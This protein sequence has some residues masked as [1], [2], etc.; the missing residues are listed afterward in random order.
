MQPLIAELSRLYLLEPQMCVE[1]GGGGGAREPREPREPR[2]ALSPGRLEQHLLGLKTVAVDLVSPAATARAFVLDFCA[3]G[4]SRGEQQWRALCVLANALRESLQLPAPAVSI[5]GHGFQLWL[6][7]ATPA[8]LAEIAEFVQRLHVDCLPD[9]SDRDNGLLVTVVDL[10]PARQASGKWAAF[11]HPGMGASF[12]DDPALEMAPPVG[13]QVGFLD[14]LRSIDSAQF[15]TALATLR[16]RQGAPQPVTPL[17]APL[18][19][20][21]PPASSNA[22]PDGL[23]LKDASL[24]DIVA[25]LHAR[26]IEPT[27]RYCLPGS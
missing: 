26:H 8:P 4:A 27:F 19:A 13:A 3:G 20:P 22:V 24:D 25:W 18:P 1:G 7:L 5:S 21:L 2:V 16:R 11:I 12:A 15:A 14:G 6:S 17:P 23:L 10:P 9:D